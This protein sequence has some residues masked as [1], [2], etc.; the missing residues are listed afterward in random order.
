MCCFFPAVF[1]YQ[2]LDVAEQLMQEKSQGRNEGG[3]RGQLEWQRKE[4][5]A[6]AHEDLEKDQVKRAEGKIKW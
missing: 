2:K 1:L 4:G 5:T 6:V 3:I